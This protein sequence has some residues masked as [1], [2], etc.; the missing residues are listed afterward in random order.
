M[1]IQS[2]DLNN[3]DSNIFDS[4][5]RDIGEISNDCIDMALGSKNSFG[6][7]VVIFALCCCSYFSKLPVRSVKWA[8]FTFNNDR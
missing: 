3:G 2:H 7:V 5:V 6:F 4:T 1:T 8:K